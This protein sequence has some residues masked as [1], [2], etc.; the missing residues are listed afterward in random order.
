M[1]K[2]LQNPTFGEEKYL[3][4][5]EKMEKDK[6]KI[7]FIN[8]KNAEKLSLEEEEIIVYFNMCSQNKIIFTFDKDYMIDDSDNWK[9][10]KNNFYFYFN[11]YY[12]DT[13]YQKT[14]II[15]E[16]SV[17]KIQNEK[18]KVLKFKKPDIFKSN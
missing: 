3:K 7:I 4:I 2:L 18:Y 8:L 1:E 9:N 13:Y 11:K 12:F 5:I 15:M 6:E 17:E 16:I 14:L 10:E